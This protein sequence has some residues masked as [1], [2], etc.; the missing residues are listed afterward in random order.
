MSKTPVLLH[1]DDV[2]LARLRGF[3]AHYKCS[4]GALV[5]FACT[6]LDE[7]L[8]E[9]GV[10]PTVVKRRGGKA[11]HTITY[12]PPLEMEADLLDDILPRE[13]K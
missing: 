9:Q 12:T 10:D 2:Q 11:S 6:K 8:C 4:V 7:A 1:L 5:R 3:A 13:S